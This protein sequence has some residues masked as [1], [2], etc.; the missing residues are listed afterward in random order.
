MGNFRYLLVLVDMFFRWIEAFPNR[1]EMAAEVA[2]T[3]EAL[4][5]ELIPRFG[6]VGSLERDNGPAFV[7]QVT[8]GI[9]SA[10]GI[11]WTLHSVWRPQLLR[12]VE[13]SS[14]TLK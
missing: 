4:L 13:R 8:K 7:S 2:E 11:F 5:K 10:L 12:E 6:P 3:A 1:I 14:Q 9:M